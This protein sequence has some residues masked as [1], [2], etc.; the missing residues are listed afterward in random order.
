MAEYRSLL[1]RKKREQPG[2]ALHH[3]TAELASTYD[4][5]SVHHLFEHG[6]QLISAS[7]DKTVCIWDVKTGEM[8]RV[9]RPPIGRGQE[10][11][12]WKAS[13]TIGCG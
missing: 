3:D 13:K 8:L 4:K 10:G 11:S 5:V 2:L 6:K 7:R 9:L 1:E 12:L